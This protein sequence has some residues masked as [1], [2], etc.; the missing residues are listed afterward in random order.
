V[1]LGPATPGF[2][3]K[4]FPAKAK[5]KPGW[6]RV[7]AN[8]VC[9][10]AVDRQKAD[11]F[12]QP[13][14]FEQM[15]RWNCGPDCVSVRAFRGLSPDRRKRESGIGIV[16]AVGLPENRCPVFSS[17]DAAFGEQGLTYFLETAATTQE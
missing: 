14:K 5:L 17:V 12:I 1:P 10:A 16:V 3:A 4:G 7:S 13:G 2:Q 6:R 11:S 8:R 15:S 9:S